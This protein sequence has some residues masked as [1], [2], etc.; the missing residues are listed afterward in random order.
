MVQKN[1]IKKRFLALLENIEK[2]KVFKR[3]EV[4]KKKYPV[5]AHPKDYFEISVEFY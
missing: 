3:Y 1:N 5:C 2:D 4:M